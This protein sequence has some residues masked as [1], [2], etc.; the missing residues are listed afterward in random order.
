MNQYLMQRD[1]YEEFIYVIKVNIFVAAVL[2]AIFPG[3]RNGFLIQR[4]LACYRVV[5]YYFDVYWT[6]GGKANNEKAICAWRKTAY[7]SGHDR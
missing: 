4:C 3:P 5:Q 7:V 1:K 2:A 6:H